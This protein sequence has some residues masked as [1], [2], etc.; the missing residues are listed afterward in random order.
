MEERYP[1]GAFDKAGVVYGHPALVEVDLLVRD[2]E[3]LLAEIK[4]SI[5]RGDVA[6]LQRVAAMY[7]TEMG[8]KPKLCIITPYIDDKAKELAKSLNIDVYSATEI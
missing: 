1:G 5:S 8:V 4:S 3:H 6:E 2:K 7:E